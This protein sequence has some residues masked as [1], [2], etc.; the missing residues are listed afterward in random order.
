MVYKIQSL[1]ELG[2]YDTAMDVIVELQGNQV[3]GTEAVMLHY[4]MV[5]YERQGRYIEAIDA[6]RKLLK[7][8][9]SEQLYLKLSSLYVLNGD[10]E[11]ALN[12]LLRAEEDGIA[13]VA[14]FQKISINYLAVNPRQAWEYAVKAVKLSEDQPEVMLWATTIANRTGRSDKAG[15]YFHQLMVN[16]QGHQ[17]LMAK[18]IDEVVELLRKAKEQTEKNIEMLCKGELPGHLFV[19]SYQGNQTYAEFFY[20]LWDSANM[21]PMEFGA[22]QYEENQLSLDQKR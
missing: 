10:D 4:E 3:V 1:V 11:N 22:H 8:N 18:S 12:I 16:R 9:P 13:T 21:A 7:A 2:E 5:I 6:G 17:L 20:A 15:K 19:D 14:V